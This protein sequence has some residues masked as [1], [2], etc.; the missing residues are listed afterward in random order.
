MSEKFVATGEPNL[1][2]VRVRTLVSSRRPTEILAATQA[3]DAIRQPLGSAHRLV[4]NFARSML[5]TVANRAY[6]TT[7]LFGGTLSDEMR[8]LTLANFAQRR[9]FSTKYQPI[10]IRRK[11]H[12]AW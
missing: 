4:P 5:I 2:A 12:H 8:Q 9:P 10:R 3:T 1:E 6:R 11:T 7:A